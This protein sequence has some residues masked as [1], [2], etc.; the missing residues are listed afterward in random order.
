MFDHTDCVQVQENGILH[1]HACAKK[2]TPYIP[3]AKVAWVSS[4]FSDIKI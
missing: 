4:A 1:H 2:G 3:M